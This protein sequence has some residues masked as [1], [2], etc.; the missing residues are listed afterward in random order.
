MQ[1]VNDLLER[2]NFALCTKGQSRESIATESL[3]QGLQ[4]LRTT[5]FFAEDTDAFQEISHL[6]IRVENGD[7]V[8]PYNIAVAA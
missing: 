6:I 1:L 5:A 2:H 8:Q 7:P 4:A 3:T